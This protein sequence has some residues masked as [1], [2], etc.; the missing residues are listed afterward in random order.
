MFNNSECHPNSIE[1]PIYE[2]CLEGHLG[3]EWQDWFGGLR[4]SREVDGNTLLTGPILDQS[5]LYGLLKKIRDL[6]LPLLALNCVSTADE[7]LP[8]QQSKK[9]ERHV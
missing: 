2:I 8:H 5:A 3:S 4:V 1:P 9:G 7:Q 6:G